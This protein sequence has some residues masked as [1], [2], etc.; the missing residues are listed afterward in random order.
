[1]K[2]STPVLGLLLGCSAPLLATTVDSTEQ[3]ISILEQQL[4]ELKQQVNAEPV[5]P[6]N[7]H[8]G[9]AVRFQYSY[10]DWDQNDRNRGGDFDFDLFRLDV[11]GSIGDVTVSAQ[12]RWY[13]YMDVVH[14]AYIGYQLTDTWNVQLG[15]TQVPF[16]Q[17][18]YASNSFFLSTGYP[19]GLED[20]FDTGIAF[21]GQ[22]EQHD[23]RLAFF[24]NDEKGGVNGAM[25]GNNPYARYSYDVVAT[26][27]GTPMAELNTL[28]GRYA[29]NFANT[30]VGVSLQHSGLEGETGSLGDHN[31]YA[32]HIRSQF[33]NI[34]V[35]FQYTD[36]Q[37]N[38]DA[39]GDFIKVASFESLETI[40]AAAK[41]YSLNVSY[42]MPVAIGPVSHLKFYNDVNLM[43]DKSGDFQ[44][45]SIMNVLGIAVTAGGVYAQIDLATG[46]NQPF[47]GGFLNQDNDHYNSRFNINI[48]YY[49]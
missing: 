22:F 9:G 25:P 44:Q 36:Y 26:G 11:N 49:F 2:Y 8:I 24:K 4:T 18:D 10:R 38:L 20:D 33:D 17:L 37:Y 6:E 21:I 41:L 7:I 28:N 29:Y 5:S 32:V 46:K 13:Q 31:A 35:M 42:S 16:G 14:H 30:E 48:G 34:E 1:M 40:P 15:I 47:V 3:R 12:Y 27:D 43:T 39:G 45:D 23:L 19:V